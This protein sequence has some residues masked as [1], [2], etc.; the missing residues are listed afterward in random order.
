M[1]GRIE[2]MLGGKLRSLRFNNYAKEELGRV[3]KGDP[4][5]AT[6]TFIDK[7]SESPLSAMKTLVYSGM[8]G[9]YE[10]RELE[11]DFTRA[12]VAEWVGDAEDNDL[13]NVFNCWLDTTQL[14]S[15]L[16]ENKQEEVPTDEPKKKRPGR[17]SKTSQ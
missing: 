10:A 15:L 13:A 6:K 11:R 2:I 1:N 17:K 4:L 5:D 16:P 8:V 14:R 9:H 3:F 12:D 7:L